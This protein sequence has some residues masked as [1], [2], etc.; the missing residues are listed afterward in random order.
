MSAT[1]TRG[2]FENYIVRLNN[3][4]KQVSYNAFISIVLKRV[5]GYGV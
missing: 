3:L 4:P 5:W 2:D 1:R